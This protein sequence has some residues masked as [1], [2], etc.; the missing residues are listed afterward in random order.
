MDMGMKLV[1]ISTL[2]WEDFGFDFL[3]WAWDNLIFFLPFFPPMDLDKFYRVCNFREKAELL[4][5]ESIF[6][7]HFTFM[8]TV[9]CNLIIFEDYLTNWLYIGSLFIRSHW[10]LDSVLCWIKPDW[11]ANVDHY[12]CEH[13]RRSATVDKTVCQKNLGRLT[14]LW[15]KAEQ[16][17]LCL[18]IS[19]A[20][21]IHQS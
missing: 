12:Y 21:F 18:C 15:L 4:S 3:A 14:R 13:I 8:F 19:L 6:T 17:Y 2:P 10:K 5:L 9:F 7:T 16:V 1:L 20:V 11:W